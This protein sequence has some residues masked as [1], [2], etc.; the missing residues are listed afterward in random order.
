MK[1]RFSTRAQV[2]RSS[3]FDFSAPDE[4]LQRTSR[5]TCATRL[6]DM[7]Y[8][9]LCVDAG[10]AGASLQRDVFQMLY[11]HDLRLTE[12]KRQTPAARELAG[13]ILQR[14]A[15][16]SGFPKLKAICEGHDQAAYAAA[17][18]FTG[19]ITAQIKTLQGATGKLLGVLVRLEIR[20]RMAFEQLRRSADSLGNDGELIAAARETASTT[21]QIGAVTRMIRDK[22]HQMRGDTERAISAAI[23]KA[24]ES[25]ELVLAVHTCWGNGSG[26]PKKVVVSSALIERIKNND[27][28]NRITR[29]LGR[30][31]ELLSTLRKNA[32]AYGRGEK[33]SLTLGR[34]L[35][36]VLSAEL[37]LLAAPETT[38]LF[39]RRYNAKTLRQ[40]ARR[41][42]V[43]KGRGDIIVCLDESASTDGENAVWAK[44]LALALQ[45]ICAHDNRQF[46]LIHFSSASEIKT[47]LFLPGKYSGADIL[48][49]AEHFFNGGT[50]FEAPMREALRVMEENTFQNADIVFVTDGVCSVSDEL[51]E[52]LR[53]AQMEKHCSVIGLLLDADALSRMF[54]LETFCERIYR[55]SKTENNEIE[56]DLFSIMSK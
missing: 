30:M 9:D 2:L 19:E 31:K 44:A 47:D 3:L 21:E 26:S 17:A 55:V 48:A 14:L 22:L 56:A 51:A 50:D 5:C 15:A 16:A 8:H 29:Q 37:G 18:A 49:A 42:M 39:I 12:Q 23:G 25:A 6:Q 35:K 27:M 11:T 13:H 45:D 38:P 33:Y 1:Y 54:S 28:L 43:R 20:H 36:N 10:N 34:D 52:A 46:A 53:S 4:P 7:I 32:Y 41:D 40:Y 24:Q